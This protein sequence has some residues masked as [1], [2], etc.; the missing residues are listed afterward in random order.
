MYGFGAGEQCGAGGDHIVDYEDMLSGEFRIRRN[1]VG[2]AGIHPALEGGAASLRLMTPAAYERLL[3][4]YSGAA[5]YGAGY[6]VGLIISSPE[7][8]ENM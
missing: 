6:V 3:H 8:F 1:G 7:F 5:G 4:R 2:V